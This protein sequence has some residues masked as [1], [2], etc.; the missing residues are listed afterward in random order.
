MALI[1]G[2]ILGPHSEVKRMKAGRQRAGGIGANI[3]RKKIVKIRV[4]KIWITHCHCTVSEY[5]ASA[6][7]F[8]T[9][10]ISRIYR[11][12]WDIRMSRQC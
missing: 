11:H 8:M 1:Y 7:W 5:P 2:L 4:M 10:S 6:T 12:G 3:N 9:E